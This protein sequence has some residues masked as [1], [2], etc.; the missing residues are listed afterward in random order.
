MNILLD[1]CVPKRLKQ[2]L[3][4]LSYHGLKKR[5]KPSIPSWLI[6][7]RSLVVDAGLLAKWQQVVDALVVEGV[8]Q[9]AP[10]SE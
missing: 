7:M 3:L 1:E 2:H 10:Y 9:L 6:D 8:T 4:F 5:L